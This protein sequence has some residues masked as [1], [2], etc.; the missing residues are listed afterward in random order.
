MYVDLHV[1]S[2][3]DLVANAWQKGLARVSRGERAREAALETSRIGVNAFNDSPIIPKR[4]VGELQ[5]SRRSAGCRLALTIPNMP[6]GGLP[7]FAASH[8]HSVA[9]VSFTLLGKMNP[10]KIGPHF[11]TAIAAISEPPLE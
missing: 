7:D 11:E 4:E 8:F 1:S 3:N 9:W 5:K 6:I 2:Q 10:R